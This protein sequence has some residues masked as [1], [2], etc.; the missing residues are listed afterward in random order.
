MFDAQTEAASMKDDL[1]T[2]ARERD[3]SILEAKTGREELKK[4]RILN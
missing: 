2:L 3:A 4:V 1:V